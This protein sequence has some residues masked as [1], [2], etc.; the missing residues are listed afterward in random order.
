MHRLRGHPI[1]RTSLA[2]R[3][4]VR[5][6][7][8][9]VMF[10]TVSEVYFRCGTVMSGSCS[11]ISLMRIRLPS[12]C[13]SVWWPRETRAELSIKHAA[14]AQNYA[15]ALRS[16]LAMARGVPNCQIVPSA[17]SRPRS[18]HERRFNLNV[19]QGL[20]RRLLEFY[21][22]ATTEVILRTKCR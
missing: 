17:E 20:L 8:C 15:R 6:S 2:S 1:S 16:A 22:A 13:D 19:E 5:L 4:G 9:R 7:P 18:E 3:A 11:C 12:T 21:R 10:A 14:P